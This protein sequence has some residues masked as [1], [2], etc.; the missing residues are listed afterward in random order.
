MNGLQ[1]HVP[2]Y[3]RENCGKH[4]ECRYGWHDDYVVR[5]HLHRFC[6]WLY[7]EEGTMTMYVDGK[8]W[9]VK[10]GE[11]ACI[12][13]HAVHAYT[14]ETHNR[15]LCVVCSNDF[16]PC[17]LE[18]MGE[19]TAAAPIFDARDVAWAFRAIGET[20]P[21]DSVRFMALL[22]TVADAF[23]R[24]AVLVPQPKRR[25][26]LPYREVLTYIDEN[27]QRDI[28]LSD[29]AAALGYHEK[30]LSA[31]IGSMGDMG[32]RTLLATCR[33]EVACRLLRDSECALTITAIAHEAGFSSINTFNRVFKDFCGV[34]PREYRKGETK[35]RS[36]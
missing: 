12:L 11:A 23:L 22:N 21:E 29:V 28:T 26:N 20:A 17:L 8:K 15:V 14:A 32:F 27:Y 7:V 33:L 24:Q 10:A 25:R 6:E 19:R 9:Q 16:I 18:K 5:A 2:A 36:E 34:T 30:Y 3:Q 35:K 1:R 31:V 4:Y 13:P